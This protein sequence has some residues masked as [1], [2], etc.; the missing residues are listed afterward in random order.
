MSLGTGRS[1]EGGQNTLPQ[2]RLRMRVNQ[3]RRPRCTNFRRPLTQ[4]CAKTDSALA[5]SERPLVSA[6]DAW[7]PHPAPSPAL[8]HPLCAFFTGR[9]GGGG[10]REILQWLLTLP[11]SIYTEHLLLNRV[12]AQRETV[13]TGSSG[14]HSF[15]PLAPHITSN[16]PKFRKHSLSLPVRGRRLSGPRTW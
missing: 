3:P 16:P 14:H 15:S 7:L 6:L 4:V 13:L 9:K 2:A 10:Y 12:S 5:E 11:A 8:C 1:Q